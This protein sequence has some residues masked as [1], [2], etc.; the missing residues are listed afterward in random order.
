MKLKNI[1]LYFLSVG[2]AALIFSS[3]KPDAYVPEALS[4]VSLTNAVPG[5]PMV[6]VIVDGLVRS[7][8]RLAYGSTT[9]SIPGASTLYLT[10]PSGQRSIKVSPDTAKTNIFEISDNFEAGRSYSYFLYDTVAGGKA[11]LLRL[12]DDL[13][14]PAAATDLKF[15]FLNLAPN[16]GA[17]D[18]T[19]VRGTLFDSSSSSTQKLVFVPTDSVT[20]TS[21]S[22][23]GSTPNISALSTFTPRVASTGAA[24][25]KAATFSAVPAA[26]QN[27][28]YVIKLKL[29]GT[30][31]VVLTSAYQAFAPGKVYTVYSR[32][33]AQGQPLAL[34]ILTNY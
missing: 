24:I 5:S 2:S 19:F 12:N 4:S 16:S 7:Q 30:Q 28:R 10:V 27:N 22:Y 29:P 18:V 3:C 23:V 13:T 26:S 9:V 33:T 8:G 14:L 17:Y 32:G 21:Q 20:L 6:D 11:K 1:F 25:A 34:S 15:R 31:T